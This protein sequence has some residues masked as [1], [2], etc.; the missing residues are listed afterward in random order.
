LV[1]GVHREDFLVVFRLTSGHDAI[2]SL[3]T[4]GQRCDIKKE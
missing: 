4:Q 1:I 3:N 2:S